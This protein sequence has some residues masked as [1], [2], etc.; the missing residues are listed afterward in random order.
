MKNT[1]TYVIVMLSKICSFNLNQEITC[2]DSQILHGRIF[3]PIT[4]TNHRKI[5]FWTV[6]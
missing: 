6:K 2:S 4:L 1:R 5:V 3:L